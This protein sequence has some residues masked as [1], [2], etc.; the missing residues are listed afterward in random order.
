MRPLFFLALSALPAMSQTPVTTLPLPDPL[1]MQNGTKVT[2]AKAWRTTRRPELLRLFEQEIYGRNS[3]GRPENMRFVLREEKPDARGGLATRLR[4][5]ILFEG[6]QGGRQMELLVYLPN[7]VKSCVPLFLGLNFDGNFTTTNEADIPLPGHYV[8][9]LFQNRP[10]DHKASEAARGIHASMFPYDEILKR[11]YGIATACYGEVEPDAAGR[12]QEGPRGI[13][14]APGEHDWGAIGAWAWALSR[15]MDYLQ[16]HPRVDKK[17][18]AVFGFSRL[19]KTAMWAGAQDERFALVISQESGKGGVSLSKRLTGEPVEHLAA[20]FPHWFTPAYA[21]YAKNEEALPVDGHCLAALVAPRPLLI[22]SGAQDKWSDPEG[23]FFGA[24]HAAP[25]YR[26][27]GKDGMAAT[28]WPP[29]QTLVKSTVGYYLRPG[30]HNVTPED[31]RATLAF[32][33]KHLK[34]IETPMNEPI[35]L[36]PGTAPGEKGD[37]GEERDTTN[38]PNTPPEKYVIRLGNVSK[39]TITVFKP[40]P[41][42]DTGAAVIVC[43]GGG[44]HILAYNLEGTEICQ[45]LNSIGV[46]GILLKYRVPGRGAQRYSTPLQDAQRALGVVRAK[47]KE[48]NLNPQRIG[49]LGFSAGGHLSAALSTNYETRIYEKVDDADEQS[50]RP[51]FA[52][53]IYP[54]YL[55]EEKDRTKIAPELKITDKTPP[56]FLVMTQD[57]NIGVENV[58]TYALALKKAK[59]PAE[60]HVYPSGGHGYGLRPSPHAISHWPRRVEDWM[61]HNGWLIK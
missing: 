5:G 29:P 35:L 56:T 11:G 19:G 46:T 39:P 20:K 41:E 54:A 57:D 7:A 16:T 3:L 21:K 38:E 23:E 52:I 45:W 4:V 6:T 13:G 36:W 1:T 8:H 15:A 2:S 33:D 44:Y 26:L 14:R 49:I 31:W 9:G 22:L 55:T 61:A 50:C 60:V 18:V 34:N 24:L 17:R 37:I 40:A 12:W 28:S 59:V 58:F 10:A 25:V 51:D 53:L 27:L 32:A 48:W 42:K 43:P 30:P 47:A